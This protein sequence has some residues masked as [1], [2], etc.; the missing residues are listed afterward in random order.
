M[1]PDKE[2]QLEDLRAPEIQ[3]VMTAVRMVRGEMSDFEDDDAP[4]KMPAGVLM[5]RRQDGGGG[6]PWE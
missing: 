3:R 1:R 2:R 4:P 5:K 6:R